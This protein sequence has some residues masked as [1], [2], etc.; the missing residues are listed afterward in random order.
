[1]ILH[2]DLG[3][4]C[5]ALGA[6]DLLMPGHSASLVINIT[7]GP[8]LDVKLPQY[9]EKHPM[10]GFFT[11]ITQK[12]LLHPFCAYLQ[13]FKDVSIT[14]Q[15]TP[16]LAKSVQDEIAFVSFEEKEVLRDLS[17]A[18]EE[19]HNYFRQGKLGEA[20]EKWMDITSDI[21]ILHGL[22]GVVENCGEAFIIQFAEVFFLL[23]L[24]I[25][26]I[27]LKGME[28]PIPNY[29][30]VPN[31]AADALHSAHSSMGKGFWK[32]DFVWRPSDKQRVKLMYR[33][34]LYWRLV[35]DVKNKSMAL[36]YV[37]RALELSPNDVTISKEREKI[38][39]WIG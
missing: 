9:F 1:M 3:R 35:G 10:A 2:R 20:C 31:L 7:V 34:A 12:N 5:R 22:N 30:T 39:A 6:G 37:T 32:P 38:L 16:E 24:N 15:V 11:A 4:F 28:R 19:G 18:K 25:A 26:H 23:Q 36:N 21:K 33:Y 13:G 14:G 17:N 27:Q 29:D 8:N